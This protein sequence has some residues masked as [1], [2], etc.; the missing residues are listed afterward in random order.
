[1]DVI[2]NNNKKGG[3]QIL[4][5]WLGTLQDQLEPSA[6]TIESTWF[7]PVGP[8]DLFQILDLFKQ[9]SEMVN[10]VIMADCSCAGLIY[11]PIELY[12]LFLSWIWG[13]RR[14]ILEIE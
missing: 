8:L 12:S 5:L 2:D 14:L 6:K 1:M 11:T 9:V 4:S 13:L 10:E 7:G 3:S